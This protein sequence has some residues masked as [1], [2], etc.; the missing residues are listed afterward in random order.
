MIIQDSFE[1]IIFIN[2]D[3]LSQINE[4]EIFKIVE[5]T[6]IIDNYKDILSDIIKMYKSLRTE[7]LFTSRYV[8]ICPFISIDKLDII[9]DIL[10]LTYKSFRK[11]KKEQHDVKGFSLTI[12][13]D[14][15][16][17]KINHTKI[18][19]GLLSRNVGLVTFDAEGKQKNTNIYDIFPEGRVNYENVITLRQN[20]D[21][22]ENRHRREAFFKHVNLNFPS[23][24]QNIISP[25]PL[26][27]LYQKRY[28]IPYHLINPLNHL[29]VERRGYDIILLRPLPFISTTGSWMKI[30]REGKNVT[31]NDAS[32]EYV[33][34]ATKEDQHNDEV[35][36]QKLTIKGLEVLKPF[37]MMLDFNLDVFEDINNEASYDH[38]LHDLFFLYTCDRVIFNDILRTNFI[39]LGFLKSSLEDLP[40]HQ[41]IT[42][43][44]MMCYTSFRKKR[45]NTIEM[46]EQH[47]SIPRFTMINGNIEPL[48]MTHN[49]GDCIVHSYVLPSEFITRLSVLHRTD[50]HIELLGHHVYG[51]NRTLYDKK[52]FYI[53]GNC[54]VQRDDKFFYIFMIINP[55]SMFN[56]DE[57]NIEIDFL[58]SS[59]S[60]LRMNMLSVDKTDT[61]IDIPFEIMLNNSR[62]RYNCRPTKLGHMM[63]KKDD[64][65]GAVNPKGMLKI[66][67]GIKRFL[68]YDHKF[69]SFVTKI[70]NTI[71]SNETSVFRPYYIEA[72]GNLNLIFSDDDRDRLVPF[73]PVDP[74]KTDV[75]R[76]DEN[77]LYRPKELSKYYYTKDNNEEITKT[78]LLL[79]SE[80]Y[81][82][83]RI[84]TTGLTYDLKESQYDKNKVGILMDS[85]DG[86]EFIFTYGTSGLNITN[87]EIIAEVK[88][89]LIN[90]NEIIITGLQI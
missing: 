83:Y 51:D 55:G 35:I 42:S 71:N 80:T 1:R 57:F 88:N 28:S 75:Y 74:K 7:E 60:F 24:A 82:N 22:E 27:N 70:L 37:T 45:G 85:T 17:V 81:Y 29:Y 12:I 67:D 10:H 3:E 66:I 50:D 53:G 46:M 54:F 4:N 61:F 34:V 89:C 8:S 18:V 47:I 43:S 68:G 30:N 79:S 23:L 20:V 72:S 6:I 2:K 21:L 31:L 77:V 41:D 56:M 14:I 39:R 65:I 15:S 62:K 25:K 32:S 87:P 13:H 5:F 16:H 78:G 73:I 40:N 69:Y 63:N 36:K 86:K 11:I 90:L 38:L 49:I 44:N 84:L 64:L 26:R 48:F 59:I 19:D 9:Y 58:D 76:D 52:I 33:I